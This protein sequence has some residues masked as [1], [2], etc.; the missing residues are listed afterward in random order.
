VGKA[1]IKVIL[2]NN[3][4]IETEDGRRKRLT[5]DDENPTKPRTALEASDSSAAASATAAA[6]LKI[7]ENPTIFQVPLKELAPS[8]I[9]IRSALGEISASPQMSTGNPNGFYVGSL[10]PQSI[11][12]RLG[13]RP[14][15]LIR[16][17]DDEE[18]ES[19]R[20]RNSPSKTGRGASIHSSNVATDAAVERP[21]RMKASHKPYGLTRSTPRLPMNWVDPQ[22][23]RGSSP[24]P[25]IAKALEAGKRSGFATSAGSDD[26]RYG[27]PQ[28][29]FQA[30]NPAPQA[31]ENRPVQVF[32]VLHACFGRG[33]CLRGPLWHRVVKQLQNIETTDQIQ[34]V[35]HDHC[36]WAESEGIKGKRANLARFDMR[37]AD[38]FGTNFRSA[39]LSRASLANADLSDCDLENADLENADLK[40]ASLAWA[41]IRD[42][43]L[44]G[45]ASGT[46]T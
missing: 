16:G 32:R 15:D 5:I 25:P 24:S 41:N 26:S 38:L 10:G 18:F 30:T 20:V 22:N 34:R 36:R 45:A 35:L 23:L 27:A 17:V 9:S 19:P 3:V 13:L 12:L 37:G 4:I 14:G 8:L 33:R 6:P 44:R 28:R 1:V 21:H 29:V 46:P 39:N 31:Q 11:L 42:A 40:G 7:H 43:N 2:R